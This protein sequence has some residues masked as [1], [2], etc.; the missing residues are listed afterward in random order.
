M[1]SYRFLCSELNPSLDN[2]II[3]FVEHQEQRD[4]EIVEDVLYLIDE[5]ECHIAEYVEVPKVGTAPSIFSYRNSLGYS[6]RL[7]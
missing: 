1:Q 4:H 3:M 2:A 7:C 6:L 5:E